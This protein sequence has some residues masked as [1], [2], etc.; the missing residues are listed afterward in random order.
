M[1]SGEG[2]DGLGG[3]A[4]HD[5]HAA[6]GARQALRGHGDPG[7][8]TLGDRRSGDVEQP[9][10]R[11]V[12]EPPQAAPTPCGEDDDLQRARGGVAHYGCRGAHCPG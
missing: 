12:A 2:L 7:K 6:H 10:R 3:V 9:L 4:G 5:A 8:L 11:V 1:R